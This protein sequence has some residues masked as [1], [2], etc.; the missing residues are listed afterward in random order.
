MIKIISIFISIFFGIFIATLGLYVSSRK[1]FILYV[2]GIGLILTGLI[3]LM[4]MPATL[5]SQPKKWEVVKVK[6][7][8]KEEENLTVK[9]LRINYKDKH[10]SIVY[11]KDTKYPKLYVEKNN[12]LKKE[13]REIADFFGIEDKER[14]RIVLPKK[15]S[16]N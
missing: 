11:E 5:N 7:L 15:K 13:A 6:K 10:P 1:R 3:G 16:G 9:E 4:I 12:F 2:L 8:P 14:V